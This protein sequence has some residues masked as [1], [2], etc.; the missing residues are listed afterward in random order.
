MVDKPRDL[1]E[2][3]FQFALAIIRFVRKLKS[4]TRIIQYASNKETSVDV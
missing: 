3:T 2:R 4:L 1:V